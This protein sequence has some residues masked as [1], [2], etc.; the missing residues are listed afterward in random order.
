[1]VSAGRHL[2]REILAR[3]GLSSA[4]SSD[5]ELPEEG[6]S[7]PPPPPP[8]SAYTGR[9]VVMISGGGN[10]VMVNDVMVVDNVTVV[11]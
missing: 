3:C 10:D 9:M 2:S 11:T 8:S 7:P 1:M 5:N 6:D 4:D